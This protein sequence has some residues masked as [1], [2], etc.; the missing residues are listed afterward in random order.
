MKSFM[1]SFMKLYSMSM[2]L[3]YKGRMIIH[4]GL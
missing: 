2:T 3:S 4:R 1:K